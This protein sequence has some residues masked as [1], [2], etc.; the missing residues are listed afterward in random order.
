MFINELHHEKHGEQGT[1]SIHPS[2][3]EQEIKGLPLP[4]QKVGRV[5]A[6]GPESQGRL[7]LQD[8]EGLDQQRRRRQEGRVPFQDQENPLAVQEA[9]G[10]LPFQDQGRNLKCNVALW[11]SSTDFPAYSDTG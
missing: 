7:S 6:A 4:H 1:S 10:Q 3:A 11:F 8:E 2:L 5:R 9:A